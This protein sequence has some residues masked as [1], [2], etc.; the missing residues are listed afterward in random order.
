M[1]PA[2]VMKFSSVSLYLTAPLSQVQVRNTKYALPCFACSS[3]P[4]TLAQLGET[5]THLAAQHEDAGCLAAILERD[6]GDK[7][8]KNKSQNDFTPAHRAVQ[9]DSVDCLRLLLEK[10]ADKNATNRVRS[11]LTL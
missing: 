3:A 4:L 9:G 11:L 2:R 8:E 7:N 1:W 6:D 5:L 10:G